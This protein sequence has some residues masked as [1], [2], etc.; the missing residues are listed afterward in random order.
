MHLYKYNNEFLVVVDDFEKDF[1]KELFENEVHTGDS[2]SIQVS[3]RDFNKINTK[4]IIRIFGIS[5]NK[6]T[7]ID[8]NHSIEEYN[9]SYVL[10]GF[11]LLIAGVFFLK[12][13]KNTTINEKGSSHQ[14]FQKVLNYL[15]P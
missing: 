8:C 5:T 14:L 3:E 9:K 4:R 15:G 6:A 2:I 11:V 13:I 10:L 12:S 7:Y 1:K